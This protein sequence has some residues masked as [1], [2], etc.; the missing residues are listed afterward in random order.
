[1]ANIPPGI[2]VF[3]SRQPTLYGAAYAT[4]SLATT[5]VALRFGSKWL[6]KT[7][8][9]WDDYLIW[10]AWVRRVHPSALHQLTRVP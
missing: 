7:R 8:R 6:T 9:G 4:F 5:A 1:M 10:A 3:A 2:D